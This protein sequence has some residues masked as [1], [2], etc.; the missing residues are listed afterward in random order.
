ML[1]NLT[2]PAFTVFGIVRFFEMNNFVLKL[3]FLRPSTLC[4]IFVSFSKTCFLCD[5]FSNSFSSKL[6]SLFTRNE[7]F[8]EHKGL[9]KVFGT[10]RFT[11]DLQKFFFRKMTKYFFQFSC[12]FKKSFRLRKMGFLL[13]PVGEEWFSTSMRIPSGIFGAVKL[14]KFQ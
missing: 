10:V 11:G 12:F 7:T 8:C 6:P 5:F 4:P 14:M 1:K 2:G 9:L 3:G 13:F